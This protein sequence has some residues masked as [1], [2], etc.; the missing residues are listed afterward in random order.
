MTEERLALS[1]LLEKAGDG[2][3]LRS[4]AEAVLQLLM[5]T[6]VEG[7][8]GA[9]RYERGGERTTWRNGHRDRVFDTRLGSLQLRIPKRPPSSAPTSPYSHLPHATHAP[10]MNSPAAANEPRSDPY[11][12]LRIE[13]LPDVRAPK[14]FN[15]IRATTA[16]TQRGRLRSRDLERQATRCR[17]DIQG[18]DLHAVVEEIVLIARLRERG[19]NGTPTA[20]HVYNADP[21]AMPLGAGNGLGSG[22]GGMQMSLVASVSPDALGPALSPLPM[23]S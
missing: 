9:G 23:H 21:S 3:F 2:D 18:I 11:T 6:D 14:G 13:P 22:G 1:E 7:L 10:P 8:I 16:L 20:V 4:V 5:E 19:R 17:D 15:L 12:P